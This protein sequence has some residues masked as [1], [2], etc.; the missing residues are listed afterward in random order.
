MAMSIEIE[1]FCLPIDGTIDFALVAGMQGTSVGVW[2]CESSFRTGPSFLHTFQQLEK[3]DA[4][5]A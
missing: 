2:G 1:N 4:P 3:Y 5:L